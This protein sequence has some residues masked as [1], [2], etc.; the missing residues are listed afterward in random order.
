M[1]KFISKTPKVVA[2]TAL[3]S[4]LSGPACMPAVGPGTELCHFAEASRARV[5]ARI[6]GRIIKWTLMGAHADVEQTLKPRWRKKGC[7]GRTLPECIAP[8]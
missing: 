1:N 7:D 6:E 4:A 3:V 2:A 8:E 5:C